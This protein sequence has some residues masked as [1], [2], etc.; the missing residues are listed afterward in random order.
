VRV[1]HACS[2]LTMYDTTA[3][4]PQYPEAI[5]ILNLALAM[6]TSCLYPYYIPC[7][8]ASLGRC[9]S[10]FPPQRSLCSPRVGMT[11]AV[12]VLVPLVL[13]RL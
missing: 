12:T 7:T 2:R 13:V 3:G 6:A 11:V 5:S 10:A 9:A 1:K 4:L 8:P